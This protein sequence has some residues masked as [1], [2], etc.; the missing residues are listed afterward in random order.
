M[1]TLCEK[2]ANFATTPKGISIS[3]IFA[4]TCL[5]ILELKKLEKQAIKGTEMNIN[6]LEQELDHFVSFFTVDH[7][8]G[9][10]TLSK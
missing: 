10:N 9:N 6:W 3:R 8:N 5:G 4:F 7:S 2:R 1:R